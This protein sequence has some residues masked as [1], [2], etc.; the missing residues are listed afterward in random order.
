MYFMQVVLVLLEHG[1]EVNPR[2]SQDNTPL[3]FCCSNG[4]IESATIL[5]IVSSFV[6]VHKC[7]GENKASNCLDTKIIRDCGSNLYIDGVS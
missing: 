1:A 2:G 3:H 5:L 7:R 6:C 4:H